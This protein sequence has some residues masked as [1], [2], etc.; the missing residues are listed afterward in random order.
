MC[1]WALD[2]EV[3][4]EE[5]FR[6]TTPIGSLRIEIGLNFKYEL[7]SNLVHGFGCSWICSDGLWKLERVGK[8]CSA[9]RLRLK[10][11]IIKPPVEVD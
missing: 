6:N 5:G 9:N 4:F 10:G 3:G 8:R 1:R 2:D 11:K 7:K